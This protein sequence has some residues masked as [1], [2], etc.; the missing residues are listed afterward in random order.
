[1]EPFFEV[2]SAAEREAAGEPVTWEVKRFRSE[3]EGRQV[4]AAVLAAMTRLGYS[5]LAT[6]RVGW[7]LARAVGSAL[8]CS[9]QGEGGGR[10]GLYYQVGD[11]YV[12]AE[13]EGRPAAA[14]PLRVQGPHAAGL[15]RGAAE[16]DAL[17]ARSY[18]WLRCRRWDSHFSL[19]GHLTVP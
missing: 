7:A 19:C 14:R 2:P 1:M 15:L 17:W 5:A 18:T 3:A 6:E 11:E 10:A 4:I 13:V 16:A 9:R 12:V 8:C